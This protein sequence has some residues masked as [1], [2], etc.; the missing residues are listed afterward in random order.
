[1]AV[2][3]FTA[4]GARLASRIQTELPGVVVH[5]YAPRVDDCDVPFADAAVAIADLFESGQ[6]LLGVC[7]A[8]ILIRLLAPLLEDKRDEPPVLALSEDGRHV[9]PLLGGHRGA[10]RLARRVAALTGGTA[11]VT[12][13]GDGALGLALDEPPPGW[14]VVNPARAKPIAAA[15][16]AGDSVALRVESGDVTW[17][18]EAGLPLDPNAKHEILVTDRAV[19]SNALVLHP[20]TLA[21]GV[22]CARGARPE[23]LIALATQCLAGY[24]PVAGLFSIDLKADEPAVHALA[25]H[26]GVQPRFFTAA[27][28]AEQTPRLANPSPAVFRE[29]GCYGV[30]EGAAL[31]AAG[32][33]GRL[34][35]PK[36]KGATVTCALARNPAGIDREAGRPQ[37]WLAIVGI[38]PGTAAWRTA[39][40]TATIAAAEHIVGYDA[41]LD[42]LGGLI[43]GKRQHRHPL[44]AEEARARRALD[45]AATG[46]GVALVSSGD[47]GIFGMASLVYELLAQ[48]P[49]PDWNRV[50]VDVLPGVSALQAAAAR[51][52]APLGHDFCAV[53]LSDLL[54]PWPAIERRLRAAADGDFVVALY[55]PRSQRRQDQ[56]VQ[57]RAILADARPA[58]TPVVVARNL[59]RAGEQ[60]AVTT[61]SE[62]QPEAVDMLSLVLVG[63]SETRIAEHGRR[64][65]VF[66]PRGY[67]AKRR[68]AS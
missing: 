22:G 30:A 48:D 2:V 52:G 45:F 28:L 54:T 43:E 9:V 26:L 56:L 34:I 62:F 20:P 49:R 13:A 66:T 18:A 24:G 10:N 29:T 11:A 44:G 6:P 25:E 47:A 14:R 32:P 21:L 46:T 41:Y 40:A 12:T 58:D 8:G 42:L 17:L 27:E 37:G 60:V 38:G 7:A 59:G 23:D 63:S 39:E 33:D 15:L 35:V 50:A 64:P 68:V 31:A 5:G 1:M 36:R 16:L 53:S 51:A 61:L 55:N 67:A 57:A 65:V 3:C 19:A 4:D